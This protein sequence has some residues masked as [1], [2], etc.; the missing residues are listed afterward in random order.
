[1]ALVPSSALVVI[2]ARPCLE[3][4]GGGGNTAGGAAS[5]WA[6]TR[7][8]V[9]HQQQEQEEVGVL[10]QQEDL[11]R[12]GLEAKRTNRT[13]AC[14]REGAV[15]VRVTAMTV[16]T[17]M[18]IGTQGRDCFM[19]LTSPRQNGCCGMANSCRS[20][21]NGREEA[22][23]KAAVAVRRGI[24][25]FLLAAHQPATMELGEGEPATTLNL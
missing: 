25:A 21:A 8:L 4:H 2:L 18:M 16:T 7:V 20:R 23:L 9:L 11:W 17:V 3:G 13:A 1:M 6:W 14:T 10:Q 12:V 15:A 22:A 19:P 24:P 5:L